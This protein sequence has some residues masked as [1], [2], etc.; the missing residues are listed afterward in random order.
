MDLVFPSRFFLF[1]LPKVTW[2]RRFRS[3]TNNSK[4]CCLLFISVSILDD[5]TINLISAGF[6]DDLIN[7]FARH[8]SLV[9]IF[10][11][12][13][14]H[15]TKRFV[16]RFTEFSV[17]MQ[18]RECN[19]YYVFFTTELVFASSKV[20]RGIY[21]RNCRFF[22]AYAHCILITNNIVPIWI[23]VSYCIIMDNCSRQ[24]KHWHSVGSCS[25]TFHW[26][27]NVE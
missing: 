15:V 11:P 6:L 12:P 8:W 9:K 10:V 14:V 20:D 13:I 4:D 24:K 27:K 17:I 19:F 7:Y 23:I 26:F 2:I 1:F 25:W 22:A 18:Q 5:W 21:I 16:S 3:Q